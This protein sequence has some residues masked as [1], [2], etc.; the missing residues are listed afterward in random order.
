MKAIIILTLLLIIGYLVYLRYETAAKFNYT[1]AVINAVI[2]KSFEKEIAIC[3][4]KNLPTNIETGEC[5]K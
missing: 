1:T 4:A 2:R 5:I 3:K